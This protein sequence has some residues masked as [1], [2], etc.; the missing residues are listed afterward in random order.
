MK[1]NIFE[2]FIG[3][4]VIAIA[5]VFFIFVYNSQPKLDNER[6]VLKANFQ[7]VEGIS[8]GCDVMVSGV[9]IGNVE[10]I[11]LSPETFNANLKFSIEKKYKFP[12]DSSVSIVSSGFLGGKYISITPGGEDDYLQEGQNFKYANP[13]VNLEALIGKLIYSFSSSS[14][15]KN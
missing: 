6:Y 14:S 8:K 3:F 9:L 12:S 7:S 13:S 5:A 4:I 2:T 10:S 11:E 1:N 15:N